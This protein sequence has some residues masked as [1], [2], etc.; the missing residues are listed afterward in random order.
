M[1]DCPE[2]ACISRDIAVTIR[3]LLRLKRERTPLLRDTGKIDTFFLLSNKLA[4]LREEY[5]KHIA[6]HM[7]DRTEGAHDAPAEAER[8]V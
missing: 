5:Q 1:R 3:E 2:R 6:R 8:P 7:C 4:R